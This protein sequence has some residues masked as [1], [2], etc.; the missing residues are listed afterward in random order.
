MTTLPS[1]EIVASAMIDAGPQLP[2]IAGFMASDFAP[3]AYAAARECV[4]D[5]AVGAPTRRRR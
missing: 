5:R 1:F 2:R 4:G 3:M